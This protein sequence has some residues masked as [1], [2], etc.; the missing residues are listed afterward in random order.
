MIRPVSLD[1]VKRTREYDNSDQ[2][3]GFRTRDTEGKTSK[4]EASGIGTRVTAARER[5]GWSREAL[6]FHSGISWSGIA[7]V[8]SGRRRNLRPDTLSALARALGVTIDYLVGGG[9]A[10]TSMLDHKALVYG[11]DAELATTAGDFLAA[12]VERSEAALAVTT[13]KN[14]DLLREQL[15]PAAQ[16][17]EFVESTTWLTTPAAAL[18]GFKAYSSA[19]LEG[20]APWVRILGEP[21]WAG[22]T[23]AEVHSWTR[24]E[25]L[26]NL[27]F[28][29]WP[30]TVLCPYDERSAQPEV[31]RQ[32]RLTHP[33][34]IGSGS[35]ESGDDYTDP[36]GFVLEPD[37]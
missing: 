5:L 20:G 19:N 13:T 2:G 27:V 6:A 17:V 16:R 18:D 34:T 14:I 9:R 26:L 25:S 1:T 22:R 10:S 37:H 32:A 21:I 35:T 33:H 23:E 29:A 8:E 12:G 7:Q 28:A 31:V 15:G 3:K 30:M 24:F 4:P 11:T 36:G